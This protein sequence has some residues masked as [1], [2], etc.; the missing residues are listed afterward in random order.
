[1]DSGDAVALET[2]SYKDPRGNHG[3]DPVVRTGIDIASDSPLVTGVG[4]RWIQIQE[5]FEAI[6]GPRP[7]KL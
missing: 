6:T 7:V 5:R 1:V 3:S 4:G 2:R